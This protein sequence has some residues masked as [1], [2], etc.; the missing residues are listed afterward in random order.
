MDQKLTVPAFTN[1]TVF[2]Q[3][4]LRKLASDPSDAATLSQLRRFSPNGNGLPLIACPR[5][6]R[7]MSLIEKKSTTESFVRAEASQELANSRA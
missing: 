2:F 7:A 3:P 5:P 4:K 1:C 6:A